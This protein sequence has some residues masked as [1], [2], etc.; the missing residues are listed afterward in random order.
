[1]CKIVVAS[2]SF[3]GTLSSAEVG[4]ICR[5]AI[6]DAFPGVIV[7]V[8]QL[9]DGGEGTVDAIAACRDV[10]RVTATVMDPTGKQI[11]ATYII[12][13]D[14]AIIE[15]AAAIGLLLVSAER[16]NPLALSSRGAGMLIADAMTRGVS[17]FIVGLGGTATVD[18]GMGLLNALGY[19]FLDDL[20]AEIEPCGEALGKVARIVVPEAEAA[21]WETDFALAC[22]VTSPLLGTDGAARLFGP[23]KGA[24][25]ADVEVLEAGMA[26]FAKQLAA[27][28]GM[29]DIATLPG[30][31]A[32]GGISASMMA[33]VGARPCRGIDLLLNMIQFDRKIEGASLVITGEGRVDRQ[34]LRG[35]APAGVLAAARRQGIPC[36]AVAGRVEDAGMLACSGFVDLISINDPALLPPELTAGDPLDRDVAARR[37]AA[38]VV[39]WLSEHRREGV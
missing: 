22:D 15:V 9:A 23:Q 2:D 39:R 10:E 30:G 20:G 36:L 27:T 8:V 25:P 28:S 14:T 37:L 19:R 31:G 33:L 5:E 3:K 12:A 21:V 16:R 32:A 1:M 11:D 35:K 4:H 13:G 24:T 34:T 17:R 6:V 29:M 26:N 38:A 7:E 18:G